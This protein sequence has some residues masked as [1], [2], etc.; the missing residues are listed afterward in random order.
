MCNIEILGLS[1]TLNRAEKFFRSIQISYWSGKI[2]SVQVK[3]GRDYWNGITLNDALTT[4]SHWTIIKAKNL[5]G[6]S[7]KQK[8]LG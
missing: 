7:L 6:V 8:N 2:F 1:A 5:V 4:L 3:N